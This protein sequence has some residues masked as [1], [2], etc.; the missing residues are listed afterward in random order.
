VT[1]YRLYRWS[2]KGISQVWELEAEEEVQAVSDAA[3]R[4]DGQRGELW[5]GK[6]LVHR[7]PDGR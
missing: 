7:F 1:W 4:L 2:D 5:R 3:E 6:T